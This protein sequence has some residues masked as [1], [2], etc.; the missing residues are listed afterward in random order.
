[1][2]FGPGWKGTTLGQELGIEASFDKGHFHRFKAEHHPVLCPLC[3]EDG[4]LGREDPAQVQSAVGQWQPVHF[5]V[6]ADRGPKVRIKRR[7]LFQVYPNRA[8]PAD[9]RDGEAAGMGDRAA[10]ARWPDRRAVRSHGERDRGQAQGGQRTASG[11]ASGP[12]FGQ[13]PG[14]RPTHGVEFFRPKVVNGRAGHNRFD[15]DTGSGGEDRGQ[16]RCN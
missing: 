14:N 9:H 6:A 10:D 3:L 7:I 4:F 8:A 15:R 11:P 13:A 16:R 1:M 2:H 5:P 12:E